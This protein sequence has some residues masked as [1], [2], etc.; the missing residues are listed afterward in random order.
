MQVQEWVVPTESLRLA[1]KFANAPGGGDASTF[2]RFKFGVNQLLIAGFSR[3][4]WQSQVIQIENE[5]LGDFCVDPRVL[6]PIW[7]IESPTI[8]I[9]FRESKC[10]LKWRNGDIR[11]SVLESTD[12]PQIPVLAQ[13]EGISV[14]ADLLRES[15]ERIRPALMKTRISLPFECPCVTCTGKDMSLVATDKVRLHADT[16]DSATESTTGTILLPPRMVAAI[17]AMKHKGRLLIR[18][19]DYRIHAETLDGHEIVSQRVSGSLPP[20]WEKLFDMTPIFTYTFNRSMLEA[21]LGRFASTHD[22]E[23]K[24]DIVPGSASAVKM[25]AISLNPPRKSEESL[26]CE[27]TGTGEKVTLDASQV[28]EAIRAC[29]PVEKITISIA[30]N[31]YSGTHSALVTPVSDEMK[32][33]AVIAT[34]KVGA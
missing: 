21:A 16:I 12:F 5:I 26:P 13:E 19:N 14:D 23:R 4:T 3:E 2:V 11:F 18:W 29:K 22:D 1:V 17:I 24:L 27:I 20:K 34:F 15:L 6:S 33:R 32:F 31:P 9:T 10:R 8:T 30:R 28:L 7:T 25:S